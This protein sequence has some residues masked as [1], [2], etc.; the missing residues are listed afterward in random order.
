MELS[1]SNGHLLVKPTG[2]PIFISSRC[3]VFWPVQTCADLFPPTRQNL[4]AADPNAHE[5]CPS[6]KCQTRWV[7]RHWLSSPVH[8]NIWQRRPRCSRQSFTSMISR[9][10]EAPR[11]SSEYIPSISQLHLTRNSTLEMLKVFKFCVPVRPANVVTWV[12]R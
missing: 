5:L 10:Y 8:S 12:S 3:W 2:R 6:P 11:H 9:K 1:E 7:G 4:R